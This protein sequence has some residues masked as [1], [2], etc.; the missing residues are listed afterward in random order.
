MLR[1]D[2]EDGAPPRRTAVDLDGGVVVV[3]MPE[4]QPSRRGRTGRT[5]AAGAGCPVHG[6]AGPGGA[7]GSCGPRCG[8]P[9]GPRRGPPRGRRV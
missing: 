5:S 3:R 9:R 2:E 6:G 4:A 1:D 8:P 7:G